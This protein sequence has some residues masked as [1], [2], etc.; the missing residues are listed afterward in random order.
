MIGIIDYDSGNTRSVQNALE[1]MD[2]AY[3]LSDN[4]EALN[5]CE[6]II[7]PGVGSAQAAMESL[8]E[9]KLVEWIQECKKPFLGICLGMQI[10]FEFS[11]EGETEGLGIMPGR[12][13]KFKPG[14]KVP[15]MGWN[16]ISSDIFPEFNDDYFYFV[17]SYFVPV[18]VF[19]TARCQYA[20]KTF[21]AM[22]RKNN[23]WGLQ[24]HPEKSGDRGQ[25]LLSEFINA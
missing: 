2:V 20:N 7:F 5:K 24:C 23:F 8:K 21:S 1:R 15:H 14:K 16:R 13:Q 3:L 6:K 18:N 10:L 17:H 25:A 19:T 12:V 11:A 22:V 4:I 9:K